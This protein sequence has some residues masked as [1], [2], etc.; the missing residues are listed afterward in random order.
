MGSGV[1]VREFDWQTFSVPVH[2][3]TVRPFLVTSRLACSILSVRISSS[4]PSPFLGN[5]MIAY[6]L[7]HKTDF[8]PHHP[9]CGLKPLDLMPKKVFINIGTNDLSDSRVSIDQ[10]IQNYDRILNKIEEGNSGVKIYLMAYYPVNPEVAA[11]DIRKC[12]ETRTNAK[13]NEANKRVQELAARHKQQFIDVNAS[14]KDAN[15]NLRADYT[16]EG[17]HIKPAGYRAI[18]KQV[19]QYVLQPE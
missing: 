7:S 10:V 2:K 16:I 15:G 11:G 9:I 5:A 3:A 19:M 14:L 18:L 13:I 8:Y 1:S 17:I 12:L 6:S 4:W